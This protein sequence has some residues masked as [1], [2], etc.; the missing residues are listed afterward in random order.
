MPRALSDHP[1]GAKLTR[2]ELG[3][4]DSGTPGI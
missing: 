4:P 2:L 3:L 1:V